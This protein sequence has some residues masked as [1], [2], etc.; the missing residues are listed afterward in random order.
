MKKTQVLRGLATVNFYATDHA[1]AKK[2]YSE[3]LGIEPYF[4][5][6]GYSEF[7][8]GDY[9]QELGIVDATYAPE[10]YSALPSGA[11]AHWHVDNLQETVDRLLSLGATLY[12]PVTDHSGGKGNFVTASVFDPFGNVLGIM[13][14]KHYLEVLEQKKALS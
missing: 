6:P 14:N 13:T 5:V 12:L 10:G 8:V 4:N 11:I 1:A 2:W 3:F 7:R 9:Q